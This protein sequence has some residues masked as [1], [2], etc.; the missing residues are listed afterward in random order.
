[1]LS[2]ELCAVQGS[3]AQVPWLMIRFSARGAYLLSVP[4]GRAL[5]RDRRLFGTGRLFLFSETTECSK[6]DLIF[7][8]KGQ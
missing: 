5:I 4:Q 2:S 3:I 7:I 8:K 6:Q 1:M